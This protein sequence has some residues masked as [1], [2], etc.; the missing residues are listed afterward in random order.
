MRHRLV[1]AVVALALGCTVVVL[2][3]AQPAQAA[4]TYQSNGFECLVGS[5]GRQVN[6]YPPK[7]TSVSGG[8]EKV[9]WSP[10]L[11]R[12]N[13]TSWYLYDSSKPWY[14]AFATGNGLVYQQLRYGTWF[15]P[16]ETP[17]NFAIFRPLHSGYYAVVDH[18]RWSNGAT[19][20]A[21]SY[22]RYTNSKSCVF[23]N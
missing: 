9:E 18:Y 20:S 14:Y 6:A 17:L 8:L 22:V 13:G 15:Q 23:Y 10:D 11:Y 16:N 12:W 1:G 21:W 3:S 5:A 2:S 19:T 4:A 7:M